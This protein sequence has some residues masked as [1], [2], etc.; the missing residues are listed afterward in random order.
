MRGGDDHLNRRIQTTTTGNVRSNRAQLGAGLN[1]GRE[2]GTRDLKGI[3]N[4][5]APITRLWVE[6]L[7]CRSVRE[8]VALFT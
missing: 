4:R 1:W 2:N 3:D 5:L 8:F 6:Q 7:S